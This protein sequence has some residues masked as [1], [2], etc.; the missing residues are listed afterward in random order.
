MDARFSD[1]ILA[2]FSLSA[3]VLM[4]LPF[5]PLGPSKS[6]LVFLAF[7]SNGS[8]D[9]GDTKTISCSEGRIYATKLGVIENNIQYHT[10]F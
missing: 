1:D 7:F 6:T 10:F 3:A 8:L 2:G 5:P 4:V 9:L